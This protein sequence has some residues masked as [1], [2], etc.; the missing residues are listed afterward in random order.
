MSIYSAGGHAVVLYLN[1]MHVNGSGIP[2]GYQV[3]A[4]KGHCH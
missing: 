3:E 1:S 4:F 2:I